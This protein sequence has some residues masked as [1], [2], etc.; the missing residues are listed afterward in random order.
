MIV[1]NNNYKEFV[2]RFIRLKG[3]QAQ[4]FKIQYSEKLEVSSQNDNS[5]DH[6]EISLKFHLSGSQQKLNLVQGG[7][8][9]PGFHII[10]EIA[11]I[12]EKLA[13]RSQRL[14]GNQTSAI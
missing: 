1:L 14:Y 12:A 5:R 8:L 6:V 7:F 9:K 13:Q 4:R 3:S 10:A 2:K 11:R